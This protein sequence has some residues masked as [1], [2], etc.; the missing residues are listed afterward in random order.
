MVPSILLIR[1][2]ISAKAIKS[3]IF[4]EIPTYPYYGEQIKASRNKV[5]TGIRLC[6][7]TVFWPIIYYYVDKILVVISNSKV[8]KYSK[9]VEITN[10]IDE[11]DVCPVKHLDGASTI[12][13]VGIG[14]IYAYHGFDRLINAIEKSNGYFEGKRMIFKIIGESYEIEKLKK[15]VSNLKCKNN[16]I[17]LGS[18]TSQ[19]LSEILTDQDIGVGSLALYKRNADIDT[20]LKVVEYMCRGMPVLSSGF[21][22]GITKDEKY[23]VLVSNDNKDLDLNQICSELVPLL[24]RNT[25]EMA[26]IAL[27]KNNWEKI[28]YNCINA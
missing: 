2:L 7:E 15:I 10:G 14:T 3:K 23:C 4:Y 28:F 19:E 6:V 13:F 20:T 25:F 16:I 5:R 9:M 8:K 12:S 24:K 11:N 26:T 27:K 22:P 1:I 18:K 17:F 21:P